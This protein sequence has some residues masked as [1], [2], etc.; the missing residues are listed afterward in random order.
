VVADDPAVAGP[1]A[2]WAD[3]VVIGGDANGAEAM[4]S[5]LDRECEAGGRDRSAV[6]VVWSGTTVGGPAALADDL[7]WLAGIGVNGCVLSLAEGYDPGA[8][9][10]AGKAVSGVTFSER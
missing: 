6:G 5:A 8:I 9:V 2:R 7:R 3:A 10:A 1:S 4:M